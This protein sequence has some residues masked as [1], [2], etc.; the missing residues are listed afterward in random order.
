[1]SGGGAREEQGDEE[2]AGKVSGRGEARLGLVG[3]APRII[4]VEALRLQGLS[5]PPVPGLAHMLCRAD[6]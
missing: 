2:A 1:M 6:T 4:Y 3:R 5:R